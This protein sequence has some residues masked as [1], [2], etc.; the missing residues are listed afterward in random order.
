LIPQVLALPPSVWLVRFRL[1][2]RV[3]A[4]MAEPSHRDDEWDADAT[5]T[6]RE[7]VR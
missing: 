5:R 6:Q 4:A 7:D 1:G 3:S 2:V